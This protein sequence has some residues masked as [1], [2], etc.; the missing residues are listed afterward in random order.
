MEAAKRRTHPL[1]TGGWPSD[2]PARACRRVSGELRDSGEGSQRAQQRQ[3]RASLEACSVK[4]ATRNGEC[5][6][7]AEAQGGA[8][9][10]LLCR[11][12]LE[13]LVFSRVSGLCPNLLWLP[14]L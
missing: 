13:G 7:I 5:D 1:P 8:N 11:C 2:V 12:A 14:P 3:K 9:P 6:R 4:S 10:R